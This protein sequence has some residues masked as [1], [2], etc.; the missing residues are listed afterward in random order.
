MNEY[1]DH[2]FFFMENDTKYH[3]KT[4]VAEYVTIVLGWTY[5]SFAVDHY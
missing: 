4:V 2:F 3:S 5:P 1:D